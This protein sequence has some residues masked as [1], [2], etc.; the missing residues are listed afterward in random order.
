MYRW[1]GTVSLRLMATKDWQVQTSEE[2]SHTDLRNSAS[3][4][5]P[6]AWQKWARGMAK[7]RDYV[8]YGKTEGLDFF[9]CF[10]APLGQ[11][12]P[13]PN[14]RSL[15]AS[16]ALRCLP[17]RAGTNYGH[18]LY[19]RLASLVFIT[20]VGDLQGFLGENWTGLQR[21][22]PDGTV[23]TFEMMDDVPVFLPSDQLSFRPQTPPMVKH[24]L[25]D[26][27]TTFKD[28]VDDLP[29][30]AQKK[31]HQ[32]IS[33]LPKTLCNLLPRIFKYRPE[34]PPDSAFVIPRGHTRLYINFTDSAFQWSF[35]WCC[36]SPGGQP[37]LLLRQLRRECTVFLMFI[38]E[39]TLA[40]RTFAVH[41]QTKHTPKQKHSHI[42]RMQ[43]DN[44]KSR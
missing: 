15:H 34:N 10:F 30:W 7:L 16:Q 9:H 42:T 29:D 33:Q 27:E 28:T 41:V 25:L 2:L 8:L 37:Y 17:W 40:T 11:D 43:L 31:A 19:V 36:L 44:L 35:Y 39:E 18:L 4:D 1:L 14:F 3:A 24:I 26:V 5:D 6:Q 21:V 32:Y 13:M 12:T 20:I 22:S 38:T 23:E